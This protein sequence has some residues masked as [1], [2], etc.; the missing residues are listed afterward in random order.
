MYTNQH[1]QKRYTPVNVNIIPSQEEKLKKAISRHKGSSIR[2][3]VCGEKCKGSENNAIL[4]FTPKQL[5]MIKKS[6]PGTQMKM[7]FSPPQIQQNARHTGGFLGL[8]AS[9]LVPIVASAASAGISHAISKGGSLNTGDINSESKNT[10]DTL[11]FPRKMPKIRNDVKF[12][13]KNSERKSKFSTG[14]MEK[15]MIFHT[16]DGDCIRV[17]PE[18]G[19]DGLWLRPYGSTIPIKERR[20]LQ[21][22]GYGLYLRKSKGAGLQKIGE[23][24]AFGVY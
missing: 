21:K 5:Q 17:T 18:K 24:L 13:T 2:F 12:H 6:Q 19:G 4:L 10:D 3:M 7:F 9:L 8:L 15:C 11:V 20:Y 16:K 23:G 1:R 14:D 22:N